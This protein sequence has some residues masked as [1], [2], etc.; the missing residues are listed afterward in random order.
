M[1]RNLRGLRRASG[2]NAVNAEYIDQLY[3]A[4]KASPDNV[5]AEW[6]H[7]FYGFEHGADGQAPSLTGPLPDPHS[8]AERLIMAYRML[9]HLMADTDPLQIQTRERPPELTPQ[10]YG[11]DAAGL[12]QPVSVVSIDPANARP[13]REVIAI[14]ER[15]YCGTVASEHMHISASDERR[16]IEQR[17]ESSHGDWAAQHT[18]Q[19]RRELLGDLTAA[20]GLERYLHSRYTGQKR[21]SLE[22]GDALIPLLDELV[23]GAGARGVTDVVLGMAH[24][25]R[26]NVL[27]ESAR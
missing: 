24:R 12:D 11:L 5:S 20:E 10:Y 9:G 25:G 1:T 21:F 27:V 13:A 17:L 22:G 16:W 19:V 15:V 8:G 14:L 26:L 2:M 23:Q 18:A 7:Y 4:F 3:E 6:R